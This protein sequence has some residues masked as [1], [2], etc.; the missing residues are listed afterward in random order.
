MGQNS[1]IPKGIIVASI[2]FGMIWLFP[3]KL[4]LTTVDQLTVFRGELSS[5]STIV[6]V[7]LTLWIVLLNRQMTSI[8]LNAQRAA[9]RPHLNAEL[10]IDDRVPD[11]SLISDQI[12]YFEI[13]D[14]EG[15][16]FI[17]NNSGAYVF[18]LITNNRKG[19]TA[20]SITV[21]CS[22]AIRDPNL[23]EIPRKIQINHLSE[24]GCIAVFFHWFQQLPQKGLSTL[25]LVKC[26]INY[27]TPFDEASGYK[28]M[29]IKFNDSNPIA[30]SGNQTDSITVISGVKTKL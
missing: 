26:N 22:L 10:F 1:L 4:G 11:K 25:Q 3:V 16:K 27:S 20:V 17:P 8:S 15:A 7:L 14:S 21:D 23:S 12:S 19:G 9:G 24:S 30:L 18:L 29:E 2:I 28:V 6:Y 13:R 5:F